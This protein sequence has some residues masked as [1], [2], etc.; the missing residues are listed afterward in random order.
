M[1]MLANRPMQKVDNAEIAAVA[2]M[3]SR[4][5]TLRQ[6]LYSVSFVQVGSSALLQTQVPPESVRMVALT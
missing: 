1:G 2:V 3:R 4:R 5:M 6:R